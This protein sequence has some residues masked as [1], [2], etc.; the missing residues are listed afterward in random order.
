MESRVARIE[1]EKHAWPHP[2][3]DN[4]INLRDYDPAFVKQWSR[5]LELNEPEYWLS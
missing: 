2:L 5:D 4:W 1:L 3:S